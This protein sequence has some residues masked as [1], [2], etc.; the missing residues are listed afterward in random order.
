MANFNEVI[1]KLTVKALE[2]SDFSTKVR[3]EFHQHYGI[4]Y[5]RK[6]SYF[7]LINFIRVEKLF[8]YFGSV[9]ETSRKYPRTERS[10]SKL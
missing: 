4:D 9:L 7:N 5:G 1:E 6:R 2:R 10:A 8:E 3:L